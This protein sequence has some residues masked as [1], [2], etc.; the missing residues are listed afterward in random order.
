LAPDPSPT[1]EPSS[2]KPPPYRVYIR[3]FDREAA[4]LAGAAAASARSDSA[5]AQITAAVA[6]RRAAGWARP[7]LTVLIDHS[8]S[9]RPG[10]R[11]AIRVSAALAALADD[12]GL[13]LEVLGFTTRGWRGGAAADAWRRDGAPA[14]PGRLCALQHIIYRQA[15]AAPA[16]DAD[17]AFGVLLAEEWLCENVDGEALLWAQ[18]RARAF[19]A[20][21]WLCL[22]VSDGA[23]VDDA[24]LLHNFPDTLW[25]H[26]AAVIAEFQSAPDIRLA[27]IDLNRLRP[28]PASSD[29]PSPDNTA[30]A[31]PLAPPDS[32]LYPDALAIQSAPADLGAVARALLRLL[33]EDPSTESA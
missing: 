16:A 21:P 1:A 7:M 3:R 19:G 14:L 12:A 33:A 5:A 8:G 15:G 6:A 26:A 27:A 4:V 18:A 11:E 2:P 32:G 13:P 25:A 23:P 28:A 29:E 24:T 22:V 31:A 30:A 9:M 17:H 10:A 20:A